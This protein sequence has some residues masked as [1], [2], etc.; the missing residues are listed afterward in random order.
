MS[1]RSHGSA[2][3]TGGFW[4][5]QKTHNSHGIMGSHTHTKTV[6]IHPKPLHT[7]G[8]LR[9]V[10]S[11]EGDLRPAMIDASVGH[12]NRGQHTH[13]TVRE[14][15]RE[16]VHCQERWRGQEFYQ[17]SAAEFSSDV[18]SSSA[19]E[20]GYNSREGERGDCRNE[21]DVRPKGR[22]REREIVRMRK[23]REREWVEREKR[24]SV[25][26]VSTK[27]DEVRKKMSGGGKGVREGDE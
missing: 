9:P 24:P 25:S 15:E 11:P 2:T 26:G 16:Y 14:R 5:E 23:P 12:P 6:H 8:L 21:R 7:G 10:E 20:G 22:D 18:P 3:K 13:K 17:F 4:Q 1:R 19:G 27:R